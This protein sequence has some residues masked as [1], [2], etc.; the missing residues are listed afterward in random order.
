[1]GLGDGSKETQ[2]LSHCCGPRIGAQSGLPRWLGSLV[3]LGSLGLR[4]TCE[5]LATARPTLG[6]I[7]STFAC[8][9]L[10]SDACCCQKSLELTARGHKPQ[11]QR[12][13]KTLA[14]VFGNTATP[15]HWQQN[16]PT[17]P[18]NTSPTAHGSTIAMRMPRPWWVGTGKWTFV[19]PP[20]EQEED[21]VSFYQATMSKKP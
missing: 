5:D 14:A 1:M 20:V 2:G 15:A 16:G 17:N 18:G 4:Q 11:W 10:I 12:P 19:H 6:G 8:K 9:C 13:T 3:V 7:S 21:A